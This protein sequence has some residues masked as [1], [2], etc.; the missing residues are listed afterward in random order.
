LSRAQRAVIGQET[1]TI[2]QSGQ[3]ISQGNISKLVDVLEATRQ[4]AE[5]TTMTFHLGSAPCSLGTTSIE[6][7][8]QGTL[9]ASYELQQA[10]FNVLALNFASARNPG[11]GFLTGA[12]AQEENL[13]RNSTLFACL[14]TPAAAP[15][16]KR[17]ETNRDPLYSHD[18]VYS[19]LVPVIREEWSGHLLA[20]PWPLSFVTAAAPNAGVARKKGISEATIT[21]V[22]ATRAELV[23]RVATAHGHDAIV[24]GAWGCGVFQNNPHEV[25][26]AFSTLLRGKY[27][28][29]FRRVVFAIVG[30]VT[31][32]S[33]FQQALGTEIRSRL[34]AS[35][36]GSPQAASTVAAG[37]RTAKWRH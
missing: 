18:I 33:P 27:Q 10:G 31:N 32:L 34:P 3:Y 16:Y 4:A 26:R 24:L 11:G 28:G 12:E 23:L 29:V 15:Y 6:V 20:Q 2:C 13:A 17:A 36:D 21:Q 7:V 22:L 37:A 8:N 5:A 1:A 30:P 19:P 25:A 9:G 35:A 14:T